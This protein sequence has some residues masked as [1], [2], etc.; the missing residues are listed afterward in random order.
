MTAPI[1]RLPNHAHVAVVL[2]ERERRGHPVHTV[3]PPAWP[4]LKEK[5]HG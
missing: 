5:R 1:L 4:W 2:Q 3:A